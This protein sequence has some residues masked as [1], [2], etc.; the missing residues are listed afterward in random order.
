[1]PIK[2]TVRV[3][4]GGLVEW[5]DKAPEQVKK[6]AKRA[7][8]EVSFAGEKAIKVGM[9]V[10]TGRARASWGHWTPGDLIKRIFGAKRQDAIWQER[11]GGLTV[12][13]GTNVSYVAE[14][15]E[16]SSQQAPAGFIDRVARKM[17]RELENQIGRIRG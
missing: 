11:D 7:V 10:D 15:N 9:P 1:M 4:D 13:Q 5:L 17:A 12:I 14:L 16:G 3:E 6:Q 2:I 8:R